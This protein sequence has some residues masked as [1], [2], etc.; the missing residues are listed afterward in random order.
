MNTIEE[1]IIALKTGEIVIVVDD[2]NRENE[3]DF[4]VLGEFATPENINFMAK[5]GRGLICTPISNEIAERL[6][7]ESMVKHNSDLHQTA[8]T[9]SIDHKTTKTGISAF[10]RSYTI[11]ALLNPLSVASDFNRPGHVFPLVAKDGGILERRGHTEASVELAKLCSSKEV[12]VICEIMNDDG[13]M[14]RM[15]QLE[16][17]A[18]KFQMKLISIEDLVKYMEENYELV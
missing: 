17:I 18:N 13:T 14:A 11:L 6:E 12:A 4:V 10:E 7:L 5:H 8:F 16:K 15:P 1:A 9:I 3:G 2:E